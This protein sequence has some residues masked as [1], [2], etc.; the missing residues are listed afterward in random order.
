MCTNM[1]CALCF[2]V[3]TLS[4]IRIDCGSTRWGDICSGGNRK[5]CHVCCPEVCLLCRSVC[6]W[7]FIPEASLKPWIVITKEA[8]EAILAVISPCMQ[9]TCFSNLFSLAQERQRE[10][11][12]P[13][14]RG[15]DELREGITTTPEH[16]A[17]ELGSAYYNYS[18][19][20]LPLL[21][22]FAIL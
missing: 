19:R 17:M 16:A 1:K 21:F 14:S 15:G 22:I 8:P 3:S 12:S 5:Y 6:Q 9:K 4:F 10:E 18:D 7:I 11:E 20:Y 2:A 13:D